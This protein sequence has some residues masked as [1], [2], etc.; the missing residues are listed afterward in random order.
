MKEKEICQYI[1]QVFEYFKHVIVVL[2]PFFIG[3]IP[4]HTLFYKVKKKKDPHSFS[5]LVSIGEIPKW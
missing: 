3:K 4:L 1:Y 5:I 2:P